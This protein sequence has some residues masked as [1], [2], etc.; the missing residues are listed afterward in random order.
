MIKWKKALM[1]VAVLLAGGSHCGGDEPPPP[2]PPNPEKTGQSC[3]SPSDCYPGVEAG[4]LSGEVQ[5][6]AVTNGYCTHLCNDDTDCCKVAGECR[7]SLKQVCSPFE[8]TSTMKMC[9]LS[10]EDA[11]IQAA[12]A[13]DAAHTTDSTA[14]CQT[15]ASATFTCRSTGGGGQ[16]RRV[17]L[18]GGT[19]PDGATD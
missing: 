10:C 14:Y 11:D 12:N 4:A 8:S 9:F 15:E 2:P 1:G 6:L 18:P 16:N 3:M 7:T 17:C 5:C 19:S 13:A